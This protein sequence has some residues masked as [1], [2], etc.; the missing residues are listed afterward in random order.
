M[1]WWVACST[2]GTVAPPGDLRRFDAMAQLPAVSAFAGAGAQ[3]V[4]LRAIGVRADGTVDLS[5][6]PARGNV[7][8]Q[9]VRE[10]PAPADAPPVGAGGSLDGRYH[11]EV[12]VALYQPMFRRVTSSGAEWD[13]RHLGMER[14]RTVSPGAPPPAAPAT[15]CRLAELWKE[16][17]GAPASAVA[18]A[19]YADGV[20]QLDIRDTPISARFDASC[21]PI[22][23]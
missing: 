14:E 11:E 18:L 17:R 9:F 19:R 7:R 15:S 22:A 23:E 16:L 8:Y 10:V 1:W 4:E 6:E 21:G 5:V 12:T 3:L 2:G 13:Y 20:W